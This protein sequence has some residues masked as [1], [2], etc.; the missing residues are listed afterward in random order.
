LARG[1]LV[2]KEGEDVTDVRLV[3]SPDV[4]SLSGRVIASDGKTPVAGFTVVLISTDPDQQK[5]TS[6]LYGFTN[7]DGSF[8]LSGGPGEYLAI[9]M[10]LSESFDELSNE[11]LRA[12][13]PNA[14]R[15]V[16]QTG[17]NKI[18]IVAPPTK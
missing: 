3:I 17:E 16:L 1:P 12:R 6:R 7:A 15:I 4:A 2:V 9:V 14:Q 18:E 5:S 8:R 10:G 11:A 13:A